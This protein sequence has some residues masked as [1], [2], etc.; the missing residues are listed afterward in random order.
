MTSRENGK[1]SI[2][3]PPQ[4]KKVV[5][6]HEKTHV[7]ERG[8][9]TAGLGRGG[10]GAGSANNREFVANMTKRG[11][12]LQRWNGFWWG[13]GVKSAERIVQGT[14]RSKNEKKKKETTGAV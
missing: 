1:T 8:G 12:K 2:K 11:K 4:K 9:V 13:G 6:W 7:R 10:F 5:P 3:A 14:W